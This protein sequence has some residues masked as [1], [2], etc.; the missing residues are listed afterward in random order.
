MVISPLS[1]TSGDCFLVCSF[2]FIFVL[3][4]SLG[5]Y[6]LTGGVG[7]I[8]PCAGIFFGAVCGFCF[9][10]SRRERWP[11]RRDIQRITL[12]SAGL[13][14]LS[15][16]LG[17]MILFFFQPGEFQFSGLMILYI[18]PLVGLAPALATLILCMCA[19]DTAATILGSYDEFLS[20][21]VIIR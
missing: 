6:L 7:P 17:Y 21:T 13:M 15:G 10:G 5:S 18:G 9:L 12:G 2:Q 1:F 20:F 8:L 19:G 3:A 14:W 11:Q 4:F 16:S